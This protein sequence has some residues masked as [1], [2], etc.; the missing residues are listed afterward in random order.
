MIVAIFAVDD[1]GG[2]GKN[3]QLPWPR[4]KED[5]KWFRQT[6]QGQ[7]VVMGKT[8][9]DSPDM[10]CPLPNRTNV[11][12]TNST[13]DLGVLQ[14]SGN[15]CNNLKVIE[16]KYPT[17]SIFVIGGASIITQSL[18]VLDKIYLTRIPGKYN[19]NTL[20][21]IDTMLVHFVLAATLQFDTC[22][23]EEYERIQ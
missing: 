22:K 5:M 21:P 16:T 11:V 3:G 2:I 4:N 18:P 15:V 12:I 7:V 8:T 13:D 17:N 20:V 6:T 23:I 14:V 1:E 10:P 9:W 19:C